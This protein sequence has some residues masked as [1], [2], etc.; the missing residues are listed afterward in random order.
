MR[1]GLNKEVQ[2]I[3]D[4]CDTLK[5]D[6]LPKGLR[7]FMKKSISTATSFSS[8]FHNPNV[9]ITIHFKTRQRSDNF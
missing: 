5:K 4:I 1:D 3:E 9:H 7:G 2:P 6:T 8:Y